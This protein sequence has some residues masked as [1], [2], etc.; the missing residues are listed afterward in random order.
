MSDRPHR[1]AGSGTIEEQIIRR[2]KEPPGSI[3]AANSRELQLAV[4]E[5][6]EGPDRGTLYPPGLTGIKRM[7]TWLSVDMSL[8]VDLSAWR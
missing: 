4:V 5:Y 1:V 2:S 8:V 7:E 3:R 6:D